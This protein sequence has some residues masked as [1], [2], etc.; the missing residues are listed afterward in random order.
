MVSSPIAG[1]LLGVLILLV[2]A[3]VGGLQVT[4][5]SMTIGANSS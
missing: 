5:G 2:I 1:F 3:V 4:S